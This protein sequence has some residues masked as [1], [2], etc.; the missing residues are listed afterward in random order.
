MNI[1]NSKIKIIYILFVVVFC[2]MI[3]P[4]EKTEVDDATQNENLIAEIKNAIDD[5]INLWYPLCVDTV[6]GGYFSDINYKWELDGPQN[7]MIVSQARHIWSASNAFM[8]YKDRKDLLKVAEHGFEFLRDYMW[9]KEFGGFY[10]L[11][12]RKGNP[13][14]EDGTIIKRAYG[15][16][17]A[18]YGLACYYRASG[19]IEIL[20]LAKKTFYW[21]EEHSYDKINGGYFQFISEDGKPFENGY[22]GTPPKDQNSSIHLL[23]AFTELYKVWK[24]DLLKQRLESILKLIRDKLTTEK[25]YLNLFF[26]KDLTPV[27][28]RESAEI[29][30]N[31]NYEFD[32]VSFGHDIETAY[33]ML[34]AEDALEIKNKSKTMQVAKKMIDH[35][36][37]FGWDEK[38][39]G[40][41]DGGYYFSDK[42][43]PKI[44]KDTKVWW[45]QAEA[46][47]SLLIASNLFSNSDV[48]YFQ[49]FL[50]QWNYIKKYLI[51]PIYGGWYWDGVDKAPQNKLNPKGSIWKVNYHTSRALINVSRN[52]NN[53]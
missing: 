23:E 33:L 5:E 53:R 1:N 16:S 42:D 14:K 40:I 3:Y 2:T 37:K 13:I 43:S 12:D 34:E 4:Q 7:K 38:L 32:H 9:D 39:G 47:N 6:F 11:I 51:D 25:G 52:L 21:L 17:F 45:A 18:I 10:D 8:F 49:K 29:I 31:R 30:R 22:R 15:N 36:L 20:E 19:K 27:S 35:T 24:D 48:N 46:L 26:T 44:I 50:S 28:F 41:Y